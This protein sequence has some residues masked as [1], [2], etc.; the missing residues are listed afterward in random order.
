[1]P[2]AL[3]AIARSRDRD[4][5]A[6]VTV[7]VPSHVAGIQLRRRL[8]MVGG[9]FAAVCFETLPRIAELLAGGDLARAERS[10]LARPI[11]DYLA[12]QVALEAGA[13]LAAVRDLPGFARVLR[14][15]FRPESKPR[16][17]TLPAWRRRP[18]KAFA[19]P[20][21]RCRR[22]RARRPW[23]PA[24]TPVAWSPKPIFH[25]RRGKANGRCRVAA[26]PRSS[27]P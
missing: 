25:T 22:R 2:G 8:A 26:A 15:A 12:G 14:D 21:A 27:D 4:A 11:G 9:R 20:P 7:I 10:L 16:P 1:M 5:L 3:A 13:P 24:A 23:G 6:P 17:A 18:A 19:R